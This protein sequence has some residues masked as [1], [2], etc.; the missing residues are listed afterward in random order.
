MNATRKAIWDKTGGHCYYCGLALTPDGQEIISGPYQSWMEVDH[1][2]PRAQG[3]I[4]TVEN[5]VPSCRACNCS[6]GNKS[7]DEYRSFVA[8][9]K[10]GRPNMS[11]EIVAWLDSV[12]F[13][14][15]ALPIHRFWFELD[16][17]TPHT[18]EGGRAAA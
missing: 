2:T 7:L 8:I 5:L 16:T 4:D 15:P 11:R 14:F 6:K 12:G 1:V 18:T 13:Q 10:S 3:G 9:K 17:T